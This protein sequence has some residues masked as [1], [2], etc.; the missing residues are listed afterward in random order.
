V[1][2]DDEDVD[3]VEQVG[4]KRR[5]G[6]ALRTTSAPRASARRAAD[7]TSSSG[8]SSCRTS[9]VRPSRSRSASI[10]ACTVALAPGTIVI[11]LRP[12]ASTWISARPVGASTRATASMSTPAR[13]HQRQRGV[14]H[15]VA[16]D[17]A[18]QDD[19][20]AGA[21]GGERLVRALAAGMHRVGRRALRLAFARQVSDAR[22]EVRVDRSEDDDQSA[23][24]ALWTVPLTSRMLP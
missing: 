11:A 9:V 13:A 20:R 6:A 24:H 2:V 17:R 16:A 4:G 18:R 22:D 14:G 19:A 3:R 5:G 23:P 7:V 10:A 1:H 21:R 15:R 12:C 8:I